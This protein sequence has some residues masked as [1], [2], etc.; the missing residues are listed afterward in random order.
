M[1]RLFSLI[2]LLLAFMSLSA[3]PDNPIGKN[4]DI[5]QGFGKKL[6][7]MD[8]YYQSSLPDITNALLIRAIDGTQRM[9]WETAPAPLRPAGKFVNFV[10]LGA[11]GA[12]LG[13]VQMDLS[14]NG[15][16]SFSFFTERRK[17]WDYELPDGSRLSFRATRVDGPGDLFGFMFLRMPASVIIPGKPVTIAI[18]GSRSNSQ[19]WYMTFQSEIPTGLKFK[20]FPAL[21][22]EGGQLVQPVSVQIVYFGQAGPAILKVNGKTE[23]KFDLTFGV[24]QFKIA[25]PAVEYPA[26]FTFRIESAG[27]TQEESITVQPV[28]QWKVNMVQHSHT[29]IGYT[30]PQTEILAEHLRYIDFALDY[31]DATDEYPKE[32]QFR[33]T[34]EAAFAVNEYLLT[35]PASQVE[36]LK[37][38]IREGRIE[39]TGMFFNFDETP[40]EQ[41]YA[42]SLAPLRLFR[43]SG[44]PVKTAMQNDVNGFGWCF[45]DYFPAAGIKYANMGINSHRALLPFDKPTAFWWESPSGSR[46]LMFRAEHYMIGNTL[47]GIHSQNFE[48]FETNLMAYLEDLDRK[49]YPYD[50]IPLQHSGY[51]TDN[52]PPSTLASD[53]IRQW[54]EKYEWPKIKTATIS[55][56]FE[57][58]E[59]EHSG[60]LPVYRAA[61]PDWW[62]DGYGSAARE[63]SAARQA[64][65]EIIANQG[66]LSLA[67]L[68]GLDLPGGIS[69][70]ISEANRALLFYDE[71]TFGFAESITAPLHEST[72][73]QR[74]LKE[75]YAWEAFRRTR[76][77]GEEAMGLL[78]T[79]VSKNPEAP[80]LSVF[81]TLNWSRSALA[82]IYIDH[83][84]IPQGKAFSIVGPDGRTVPAQALSHRSDG[85]YWG[86]W[87]DE[88]PPM[89][90]KTYA[91]RVDLNSDVKSV[92]KDPKAVTHLD[93][94]YY[95]CE[96]DLETG[97]LKSLTDKELN[98]NLVDPTAPWKLGQFI[99]ERLGN[100]SQLESLT[101]TQYQR[102]P[103]DTVWFENYEEGP[104]WNTLRFKGETA[105]AAGP[106][107]FVVEIRFYNTCK[108]IDFV[109][110][111]RKQ[112][113]TDPES[114]YIAFPFKLDNGRI[115]CE[116]QGGVMEAGV[117]QIPG[118]TTDWNT[119]QN[120]AAVRS[121]SGQILLTSNKIPLM[122]F[123]G[124]NTG[125][126]QLGAK[127][128]STRIYGWPMNNYW[129]T[130]FNADQRGE[131]TF[132]Y[133]LTSG[134]DTGNRFATRFGWGTRIPLLV[135]VIPA[136]KPNGKPAEA[137][138]LTIEPENLLVVNARPV[139]EE[140]AIILQLRE[141][142]GVKAEIKIKDERG[143]NNEGYKD[144][145]I[146]EVDVTGRIIGSGSETIVFKPLESKFIKI[147]PG[148]K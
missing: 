81:N 120:F 91:I 11:V 20:P 143:K 78:Q 21:Y 24:H 89:G 9:E 116:V 39:V 13:N 125:R 139:P 67:M 107:G 1:T 128:A 52:S 109:Y 121:K 14:V 79:L 90:Y 85:T 46:L 86:F 140:K 5:I 16:P 106:V 137:S 62:T 66:A 37:N 73:D 25:L 146:Q 74:A 59:R 108:K 35:R 60:D 115:F 7:G 87:V 84:I 93:T 105:A 19:A 58:I 132:T 123:G 57:V 95:S 77:V 42:A 69:S 47:M 136:G 117:D 82:E 144:Y 112:L 49:G 3:Q 122:Q 96:I 88:V 80:T 111:I 40:D 119:V 118:S 71:H 23:K 26:P 44:I 83:Q 53:M 41:T 32:S 101:L 135:R 145:R 56:F 65:T 100:R 17:S 113:I 4:E 6:S 75:S 2:T 43:E 124:I 129:T 76:M 127:P 102:F 50:I 54:N 30:R 92:P 18:T 104:V 138:F 29:D 148:A 70:R 147:I 130:N 36:R 51:Q 97:A 22:R 63:V 134:S 98:I 141:V 34:C 8:F 61:W 68:N 45:A 94:R 27:M 48:N 131:L 55:E 15:K 126:Y 64:H 99:Y 10:W 12:N 33:W 38:R 103:L 110:T 72:M 142:S 114:I 28:K 133:S 31:C